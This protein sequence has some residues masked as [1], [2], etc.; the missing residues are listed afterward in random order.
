MRGIWIYNLRRQCQN[1]LCTAA[2][3]IAEHDAQV[4]W[5]YEK[6]SAEHD[7]KG[8]ERPTEQAEGLHPKR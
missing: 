2:V 4:Q 1:Q 3:V 7:G 8:D 5:I 6:E